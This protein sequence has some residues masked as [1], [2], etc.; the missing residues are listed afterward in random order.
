MRYC[1]RC[2]FPENA[3]PTIIFDEEGV[4]SGCRVVES[5]QRLDWDSREKMFRELVAEYKA[6]AREKGQPYDCIIPVSGGKDSHYQVYLATQVYGLRPLLVTYNHGFNT[7]LGLRNL[8]N[9][10]R[11][12]NCDLLRVS[13]GLD[14]A[15]RLSRYMLRRCGDVTW[16]YHAGIFTVPF[17]VAVEKRIPLILW[18]DHARSELTGQFRLE[19][20]P[21]FTNWCRQ[22]YDMRGIEIDDIVADPESGLER[23]E[24]APFTFPDM[25]LMDEIGVRGVYMGVY[26]RWDAL[27]TTKMLM[28]DWGF[29]VHPGPREKTFNLY[30]KIDDHANEVHDYLKYLKFGYG[31]ATDHTAEE[32]RAGRMTREEGIALVQRYDAVRPSSLDLYLDFLGISEEEF[33]AA[34]EDQR[35]PEVW[36]KGPDGRWRARH[37][38][39]KSD[40]VT[41]NMLEAARPAL[42]PEADRTFG[43]NNRHLYYSDI[44]EPWP[45]PDDRFVVEREGPEFV[46]V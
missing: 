1:A 39:W 18:G 22:Q 23:H 10:V 42:V 3:R 12:F 21:E 43:Y 46:V 17:Q 4:C 14:T 31:R 40:S 20:M 15:R 13:S 32:I 45:H 29:A 24:L 35:D 6:K 28:K 2:T 38:I 34:I 36:E 30:H 26:I 25:D 5:K 41:S 27:Q 19:D 44:H 7:R 37:A 33:E 11:S 9:L 8:R 16:H